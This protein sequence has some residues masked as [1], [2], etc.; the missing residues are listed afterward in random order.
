MNR[1]LGKVSKDFLVDL[2]HWEEI[3][4]SDIKTDVFFVSL[5]SH[6]KAFKSF[7]SNVI[8]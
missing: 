8:H 7:L 4:L 6:F 1:G 3:V 5:M 2:I